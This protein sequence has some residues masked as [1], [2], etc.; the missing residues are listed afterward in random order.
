MKQNVL[1]IGFLACFS[2]LFAQNGLGILNDAKVL[3]DK[4]DYLN[5]SKAYHDYR[6]SNNLN[7][8]ELMNV[9]LPEAE[10]YYMLDDYQ[11]LDSL[12]ALYLECFRNSRSELGDDSL[13]V[14]KAYLHK[15]IG[16]ALYPYVSGETASKS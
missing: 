10:C 1:L 11:Q 12:T 6:I 8:K 2:G 14:Y 13:Y 15:L 3:K 9:L 16:N 7:G 4:G 5:A